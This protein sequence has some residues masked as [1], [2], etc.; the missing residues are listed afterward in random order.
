MEKNWHF[1]SKYLLS[2][3]FG[4]HLEYTQKHSF[5]PCSSLFDGTKTTFQLGRCPLINLKD[6]AQTGHQSN[7]ALMKTMSTL[8]CLLKEK[9][10]G[11]FSSID[12]SNRVRLNLA[13]CCLL[14]LSSVVTPGLRHFLFLAT[15]PSQQLLL[16]WWVSAVYGLYI[17]CVCRISL[18]L[19]TTAR[20]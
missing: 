3:N 12:F 18:F 8:V 10:L 11:R 13:R 2:K 20:K 16:H 15:A 6:P 14:T 9:Q 4:R 5:R 19:W 1:N 17:N 7:S